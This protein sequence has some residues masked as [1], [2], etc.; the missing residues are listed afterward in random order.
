VEKGRNKEGLWRILAR[1]EG[2]IERV[3]TRAVASRDMLNFSLKLKA[4]SRRLESRRRTDCLR[5]GIPV[6]L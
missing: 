4:R 6:G 1:H 5:L 3:K 2:H